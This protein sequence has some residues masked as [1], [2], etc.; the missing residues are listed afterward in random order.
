MVCEMR[1]PSV[2]DPRIVRAMAPLLAV[3][4]STALLIVVA[5]AA[6]ATTWIAGKASSVR[7]YDYNN[8]RGVIKPGGY[9]IP[10][11]NVDAGSLVTVRKASTGALVAANRS[12]VS[13]TAGTYTTYNYIK[14]KKRTAYSSTHEVA[15]DVASCVAEAR[16]N[17]E[18]A[19]YVVEFAGPCV[20]DSGA[21]I[22]GLASWFS[23]SD[24][25]IGESTDFV[26]SSS[27]AG[28]VSGTV[29]ESYTAYKYGPISTKLVKRTVTVGKYNSPY[30][31]TAEWGALRTGQSLSKVQ[32]ILGNRGH[33]YYTVGANYIWAFD[34]VY[35]D[36]SYYDTY[37]LLFKSGRLYSW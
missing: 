1:K 3:G 7:A 5:P 31:T 26:Y 17:P 2:T 10:R 20:S 25:E 4:V 27:D 6:D 15:A 34:D 8:Y 35:E 12:A 36:G 13:A 19:S 14:F 21:T 18:D 28:A 24:T 9:A 11:G 37:Y 16:L 22:N 23:F 30:I 32:S 33:R 29:T